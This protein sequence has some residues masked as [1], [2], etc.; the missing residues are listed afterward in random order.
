MTASTELCVSDESLPFDLTGNADSNKGEL[1]VTVDQLVKRMVDV[2]S[3]NSENMYQTVFQIKRNINISL[4][5]KKS[6]TYVGV[7]IVVVEDTSRFMIN[8][9]S[10]TNTIEEFDMFIRTAD[11]RKQKIELNFEL[12][13]ILFGNDDDMFNGKAKT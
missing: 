1:Q 2:I 13:E 5:S 12:P 8:I 6:F 10:Q 4:L 7:C 3:L 11:A 9:H